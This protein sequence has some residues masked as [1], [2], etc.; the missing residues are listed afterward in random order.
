M[1]PGVWITGILVASILAFVRFRIQFQVTFVC[2]ACKQEVQGRR[3]YRCR[4]E[5][6]PDDTPSE[7]SI[8]ET[9]LYLYRDLI[10]RK[11]HRTP[12]EWHPF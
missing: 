8:P 5:A 7:M 1:S 11:I 3:C 6:A 10:R 9:A 2:P 12:W 4:L